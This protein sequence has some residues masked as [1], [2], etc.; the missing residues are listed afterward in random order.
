[1]KLE[2]DLMKKMQEKW[3]SE[4]NKITQIET[5]PLKYEPYSGKIIPLPTNGYIRRKNEGRSTYV[6][7]DQMKD[8]G[9][10]TSIHLM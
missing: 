2:P 1:M 4:G 6:V 8:Y 5:K 7:K 9:D 3:L 10:G